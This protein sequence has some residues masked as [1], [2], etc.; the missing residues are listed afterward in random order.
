MSLKNVKLKNKIIL[1]ALFIILVFSAM[2]V[3]YIL[4]TV[5]NIIE[6]RTMTKLME[7]TDVPYAEIQR[8]YDLYQAGEKTEEEAQK[9]VFDIIRNVRYSEVEYFWINTMDGIMLM[10]PIAEQ[11]VDTSVIDL[12]DTDGKYLFQDM[13]SVVEKDGE[14]IVRYQWPKPGKDDPQ[15]KISFVKGFDKWGW[16]LGTGVYVDDLEE[17]KKNI[18]TSVVIISGIIIL[19]SILIIGLIVI[20][21]NRTLRKIIFH[22][23]KYKD[24]DFRSSI[25][26]DSNDELGEISKAFDKVSDSL[27]ELLNKMIE[28]SQDLTNDSLSIQSDVKQLEVSTDK[29]LESTTDI[30]AVIEQTTAATHTVTGTVDEIKSAIDVIADKATEGA[31]KAGDVSVRASELKEDATKS[32]K[33]A[34]NIYSDVKVRL[35]KAIGDAKEV[36]KISSLLDGILN[37]TSQTN[38]LAL[39]ASIEAARAGEAGRGFAVVANEVG[40]LAEASA[41]MVEDIQKTVNAVQESVQHLIEDSSE[42]LTFI[43]QSVLKD[44][45]KLDSISDQYSDD[46]E[47]FNGIMMELS[48]ISEQLTSSMESISSNMHEVQDATSQEASGVENILMM[49]KDIMD[50]ATHANEIIQVNIGMIEELDKL[51]NQFNI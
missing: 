44:Y 51:I 43:D 40:K 20:P 5:S 24:L 27:R 35:E 31:S 23:D 8:Q 41:N 16:V 38:L 13:I 18:Y 3:F 49:T 48:A 32:S 30:S 45:D 37:L 47:V 2:I 15:P 22:T 26:I 4:P 36:T 6:D 10:H 9:D 11:L 39:N 14:G 17:I 42:I 29:T 33:H 28:T 1:L 21:L 19:F 12:Q 46:A 7:L 34:H 25:N 50:K